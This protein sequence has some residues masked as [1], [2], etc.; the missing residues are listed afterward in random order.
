MTSP[1]RTTDDE[2]DDTSTIS[3]AWRRVQSILG[4]FTAFARRD[5]Q[6]IV[7]FSL[8]VLYPLK[9]EGAFVVR[10]APAGREPRRLCVYWRALPQWIRERTDEREGRFQRNNCFLLTMHKKN[11]P[12][13]KKTKTRAC[14]RDRSIRQPLIAFLSL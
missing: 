4:S 2:D 5:R 11:Q 13:K 10:G 12:K 3:A 14:S 6:G 9:S 8:V 7:L 1:K